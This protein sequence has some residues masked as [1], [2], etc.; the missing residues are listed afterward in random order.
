M[1][2]VQWGLGL[3]CLLLG[4]SAGAWDPGIRAQFKTDYREQGFEQLIADAV[5]DREQLPAEGKQESPYLQLV[6]DATRPH[7]NFKLVTWVLC[8]SPTAEEPGTFLIVDSIKFTETPG[9]KGQELVVSY[10]R[11]KDP[12]RAS[13]NKRW[14]YALLMARGW[15]DRVRCQA[16]QK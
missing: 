2:R 14:P 9:T 16:A 13:T 3:T 5:H 1:T 10:R 15:H 6:A 4:T 11:L 7:N 12:S 8:V